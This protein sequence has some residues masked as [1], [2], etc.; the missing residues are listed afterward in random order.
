MRT[1]YEGPDDYVQYAQNQRQRQ[2]YGLLRCGR[3]VKDH[4][5]FKRPQRGTVQTMSVKSIS[6]YMTYYLNVDS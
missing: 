5:C 3:D 1:V 4:L 2:E 6:N